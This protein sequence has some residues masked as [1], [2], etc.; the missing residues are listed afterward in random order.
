MNQILDHQIQIQIDH[1]LQHQLQQKKNNRINL[2][3]LLHNNQKVIQV[4]QIHILLF[5]LDKLD[6]QF[7][8]LNNPHNHHNN[9]I[10]NLNH[11]LIHLYLQHQ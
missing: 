11:L 10:L 3:A 8:L 5:H 1:L 6:L 4:I 7:Q 9:K 2:I